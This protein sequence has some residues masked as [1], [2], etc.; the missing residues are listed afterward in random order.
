MEKNVKII[1]VN[2][3][4]EGIN[5]MDAL[6]LLFIGLKLTD[7]LERWT[8]VE[9]LSPLWAP[10]MVSWFIILLKRTFLNNDNEDENV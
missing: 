2:G 9:V 5:F 4:S 8:W 10:L 6:A 1:S 3:S 7:H